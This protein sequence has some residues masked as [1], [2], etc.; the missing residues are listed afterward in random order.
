MGGNLAAGLIGLAGMALMARTLGPGEFGIFVLMTTYVS[1]IDRLLNFQSWQAVIKYG[2]SYI[3]RNDI[4][5]FAPIIKFTGLLDIGSAI[6]GTLVAVGGAYLLAGR[7]ELSSTQVTWLQWY[8]IVIA[9]HL[10]GLP[11]GIL[12]LLDRFYILSFHQVFAAVAS[13]VGISLV[14]ALDG[15]LGGM[16]LASA[17]G[18]CV[19]HLVLLGAGCWALNKQGI[20]LV[21]IYKARLSDS[22]EKLKEIWEFVF[23]TNIES[24]VKILRELD[25]FIIKA[26]LSVEAVGLYRVARK[27]AEIA[28]IIINPFFYAVYPSLSRLYA[29]QDMA[30]FKRLVKQ[31]SWLVGGCITFGWISFILIGVWFIQLTFGEAYTPAYPIAIICMAAMA[32]WGFAQP[33]AP[34]L[35]SIGVYKVIFKI[36]LS[37]AIFYLAMLFP[38]TKW[39]GLFGSAWAFTIFYF[40]WSGLMFIT[41]VKQINQHAK[42]AA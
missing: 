23:Y 24:S 9:L 6:A 25:V 28:S 27:L 21:D 20:R 2:A 14:W 15:G 4:A 3:G 42:A 31:S 41:L 29:A 34:A 35:Y 11:T 16:I 26:L 36:H 17:I 5:G 38:M 12:R 10:G 37:T 19:G 18:Q 13:L 22:R 30:G 7:L 8:S 1:L 39:L 40:A 32:V 33:L